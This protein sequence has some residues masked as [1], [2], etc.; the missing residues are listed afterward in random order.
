MESLVD[1]IEKD[2]GTAS[3][4]APVDEERL[5][6]LEAQTQVLAEAVIAITNQHV[7]HS[8]SCRSRSESRGSGND[9]K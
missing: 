9:V 4:S 2:L 7:R 1:A 5:S 6:K 8:R 3:D